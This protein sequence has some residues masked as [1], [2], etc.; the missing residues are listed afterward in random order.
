MIVNGNIIQAVRTLASV[1][2][3]NLNT[4]KDR[5][6]SAQALAEIPAIFSGEISLLKREVEKVRDSLVL[7]QSDPMTTSKGKVRAARLSV[8]IETLILNAEK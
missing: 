5:L 6:D 2:T 1:C 7:I 8:Q 3:D 4:E